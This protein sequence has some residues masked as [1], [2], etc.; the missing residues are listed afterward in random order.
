M[1]KKLLTL[2][3]ALTVLTV[4]TSFSAAQNRADQGPANVDLRAQTPP[5][6]PTRACCECLGKVTTLDLLTGQGSPV[7]PLW[8]MNG[9]AAYTTPPYPGWINPANP[10]L[11]P[12]KWIQPVASP[13]PSGN[14]TGPSYTY[15]VKFNTPRCTI[16]SSVT[17]DVY[18]AA[19][20]GAKVR[21]DGTWITTTQCAGNCFNT[22]QAPA[23]FSINVSPTPLVHQLDFVVSNDSPPASGLIVNAKLTRTCTKGNPDSQGGQ[24]A[25]PN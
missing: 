5:R 7:D 17:L 24:T 21:L 10:K 11:T 19:D 8:Q 4:A 9:G 23:H 13:T 1:M 22:P 2:T 20:N 25:E 14:V 18:F 6:I 12:A 3:L 15:T 16:P